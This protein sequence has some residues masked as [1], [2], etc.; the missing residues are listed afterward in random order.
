[1]TFFRI[2]CFY[3]VL[4]LLLGMTVQYNNPELLTA[5]AKSKNTASAAAS[6]FVVAALNQGVVG[7]SVDAINAC[8]LVFTFS[9][10]NSDLY[11]ATRTLYSLAMEG[12]APKIFSRTNERGVPVYALALSSAFC[13]IAFMCQRTGVFYAFTFLVSLVTIFG[14]LTW[15]SILVSHIFFVRA[16]KA[17]GVP[18]SALRFISP[19]GIRGSQIALIFACVI[20]IFNGFPDFIHDDVTG[21]KWDPAQF[22]VDYIPIPIYLI[23]IFGYKVF[24]KSEGVTP[25]G[26]DL[27]GGKAKIDEDEAEFLEEQRRRRGGMLETRWEKYY[28]VSLGNFF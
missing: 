26:A 11:I 28:R 9:A 14:I 3:M 21:K 1:L 16:R 8:I 4:I 20:T 12:N 18:D 23:M 5:N 24:M 6:P 10:A 25:M 17:Q 7:A 13:C 19:F 2:V 15:I 27:F 22:V